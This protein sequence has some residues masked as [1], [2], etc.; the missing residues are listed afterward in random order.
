LV[1]ARRPHLSGFHGHSCMPQS[2]PPVVRLWL[3]RLLVPMGLHREF[4]GQ[5]GFSN[6]ALAE[7]LGLGGWIDPVPR[8]FDPTAVRVE[9]RQLYKEA[10]HKLTGAEMSPGLSGNVE[11]LAKLVGLSDTDCRILEFVVLI[12]CEQLL[13][14]IADGLGPL[15]TMKA[16]HALSMLLNLPEPQIRVSLSPQAVLS[17]SGL[18][19]V[20][21]SGNYNLR[22][23]FS[24][25]SYSFADR[26]LAADV[27]PI[28]LLRGKLA[29][30]AP[31][32]LTIADYA[33][34]APSLAILR[35]YLKHCVATGRMGGNVFLYG[36]PGTGKS[37]LAKVLAKEFDCELFEVASEDGDGDPVSGEERLRAFRAGQSFFAQRRVLMLFDEVED[38]FKDGNNFFGRKSAAQTRKGWINR[39]LEENS[40]PTLWLSNSIDCL[41][42][43]FIRRFDLVSELPVPPRRQR[44][45]IILEAC[46]DLLDPNSVARIAES[47]SL[48]PAVVTRVASVVGA[49]RDE[50][51]AGTAGAIE[52]LIDNTLKAQGHRAIGKSNANRLPEIY[53]PAF[54][55]SDTDL[56]NVA[57]GLVKSR[58][59]RMCLYGPPGTG[60]TAY[61]RWLA[62]QMGT[63]LLEK[64]TSDLM[65]MWVGES[66]KNIARAFRQAEQDGALLLID[67]VDSFLQDRR[68][69][70]SS[71]EVTL[72]NEMLTQMESFPGVF[73]ASTNL[74]DGLD[75]A[76]LR[77]FDI[78]VKFGFLMPE[79]AEELLRRYCIKWEIPSP[80]IE[81][82]TRLPHLQ[83]L[84]PGD[85]AAVARQ[86]QFRP[87][88]SSI[89]LMTALEAECAVKESVRAVIGFVH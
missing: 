65:S 6:D 29:L 4:V 39:M 19:S 66:E 84:T 77:R 82:L 24:L 32:E 89:A 45:R 42:P 61:A 25:L 27:D 57:A 10:E 9:L 46:S 74:M 60:K 38:V 3:F 16:C 70:R 85:F 62:D 8:D 23:K 5:N 43:A 31:A 40:V 14:D 76:A 21:R 87:I 88:G 35:P 54:I 59:G 18:L 56:A 13:D 50:L 80:S 75:Q 2:I 71:W 79:Q 30:S 53:D 12:N 52:L 49:I 55:H 64:R 48:S 15:S 7:M 58:E 34:I 81:Q 63:P 11:H 73:I 26:I 67:E 51:G 78:K 47:E 20:N 28:S 72:V 1:T 69:A 33:H 86:H 22:T 83:N 44:E 17:R 41:D 68:G 36:A 37:Q